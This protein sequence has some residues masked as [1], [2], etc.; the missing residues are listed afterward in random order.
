MLIWLKRV[1]FDPNKAYANT[2]TSEA[3]VNKCENLIKLKSK[4]RILTFWLQVD[5]FAGDLLPVDEL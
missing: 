3:N 2:H 4:I 1:V 5:G